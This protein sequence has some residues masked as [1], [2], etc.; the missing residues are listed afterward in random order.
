MTKTF[1]L[2]ASLAVLVS[3]GAC[4]EPRT[5]WVRDGSGP[6]ELRA[7]RQSCERELSGYGFVDEARFD[8]SASSRER[9]PSSARSDVY[10]RCME[11]MGW[12]RQRGDA[13]KQ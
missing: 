11:S 2:L 8:G 9:T 12:R 4:V 13:P 5:E 1:K 7:A 10:R 3:L 6:D